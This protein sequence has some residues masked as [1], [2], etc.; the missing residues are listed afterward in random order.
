MLHE[1]STT[2]IAS[3]INNSKEWLKFIILMEIY[4]D[5]HTGEEFKLQL[6]WV[7]NIMKKLYSRLDGQHQFIQKAIS[8]KG[9]STDFKNFNFVYYNKIYVQNN[10]I[11]SII[12]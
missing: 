3:K 9:Y 2:Y 8:L 10:T 4:K 5:N 7:A 6:I 12:F 1:M 11:L